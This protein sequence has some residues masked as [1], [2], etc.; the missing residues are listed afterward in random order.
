MARYYYQQHLKK[1]KVDL[2]GA[3]DEVVT[4]I[5]IEESFANSCEFLAMQQAT[6]AAHRM[7][8]KQNSYT[9]LPEHR[10]QLKKTIDEVGE[11]SALKLLLVG[12]LYAN[13]LKEKI[14][15]QELDKILHLL[16]VSAKE[17]FCS[18]TIRSLLKL[19]FTLDY[20]FRTAT[21]ALHLKLNSLNIDPRTINIIERFEENP[22]H[23]KDIMSLCERALRQ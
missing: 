23:S 9:W 11:V 16:D 7:F 4:Q 10:A 1:E 2:S 15:D 8:Y 13:F 17:I 5:F 22:V 19:T 3:A 21:S 18:R 20:E 12:Y 14:S 6:D